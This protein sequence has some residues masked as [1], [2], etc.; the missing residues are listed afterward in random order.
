MS[1][2]GFSGIQNYTAGDLIRWSPVVRQRLNEL[3]H[4]EHIRRRETQSLD[5]KH[6]NLLENCYD[7]SLYLSQ[8][9][10]IYFDFEQIL[11]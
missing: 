7:S 5:N 11:Q 1:I 3:Y 9:M 2:T 4:F 6:E 10:Q 8:Q